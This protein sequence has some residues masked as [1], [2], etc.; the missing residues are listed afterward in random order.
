V[1]S[2]AVLLGL[3]C[4]A[5]GVAATNTAPE[6]AE[7]VP[8]QVDYFYEPGCPACTKV[9]QQVIIPLRE[10]YE[11]FYALNRYDT[12]VKT[13]YLA[14]VRL[15]EKLQFNVSKS[16]IMFVDGTHPFAGWPAIRDGVLEQVD[17]RVGER[18]NPGT[19][20]RAPTGDTSRARLSDEQLLE[21][22][23]RR[24]T[25]LGVAGAGLVD[26]INPCA[27]STLVFLVSV[28]GVLKVGRRR[29]LANGLAFCAASFATYTAIGF[30]LLHAFHSLE[31]FGALQ[32]VFEITL[33]ALLLVLAAL[34]F[35]DAWR[36]H[37]SHREEEVTLRLPDGLKRRIKRTIRDGMNARYALVGALAAGAIVTALESVCT[38][39]VYVPTLVLVVKAGHAGARVLACLALYNA[40]FILPLVAVVGLSYT[41]LTLQELLT[42]SRREVAVAKCLTGLLFLGMAALLLFMK[43]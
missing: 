33:L 8:V 20:P 12:R 27:I 23:I 14:L 32:R 24:F 41:G 15:Q 9:E 19:A 17:R 31:G 11:G 1:R 4:A 43:P 10:R 25:W 30:G 7:I 34:S 2:A 26:G 28:L 37:R 29:M 18:L 38:G 39:Q 35:R 5:D 42:W 22:R 13:N 16:V 21:E 3:W 6:H 36:Y 40:M